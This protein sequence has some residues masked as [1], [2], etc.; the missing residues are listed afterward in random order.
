MQTFLYCPQCSEENP[1]GAK[2]C[3]VCAAPIQVPGQTVAVP[4]GERQVRVGSSP[5][6]TVTLNDDR[7]SGRHCLLTFKPE[8]LYIQDL[9]STNG[10]FV[11]QERLTGPRRLIP[12]DSIHLGSYEVSLKRLV[13]SGFGAEAWVR[14]NHWALDRHLSLTAQGIRV[15]VGKKDR[16]TILLEPTSLSVFPGELCGVMGLAGAGK[17][18]LLKALSGYSR[19]DEGRVLLNDVDLYRNFPAVKRR[20]GYVPQENIFHKDLTVGQALYCA[21]RMRLSVRLDQ[22]QIQRRIHEVVELLGLFATNDRILDTTI[23]QCSGGQQRRINI[24][25]ELLHDPDLLF[26]DEPLSGLSSEDAAVLMKFLKQWVRE[27]KTVLMTLHQPNRDIYQDLD[28]VVYLHK[29]G[30]LVFAGPAV[31]DSFYFALGPEMDEGIF[32]QPERVLEAF[33][34]QAPRQAAEKFRR[35][36]LFTEYCL[37]KVKKRLR[38]KAD[39]PLQDEIGMVGQLRTLFSRTLLSKLRDKG[40]AAILFLQAPIIAFLVGMVFARG[41]SEQIYQDV[42]KLMFILVVAAVWFGCS[43]AAR[44][45]CGEWPIFRRER[46]FNLSIPA[47]LG[48][49][50]G[51]GILICLFQCLLLAVIV[52]PW[53]GLRVSVVWVVFVLWIAASAGS[54]I[55]LFVSAFS[56][57][58]RKSNEIALALVPILLIPMVVLGG[59]LQPIEEMSA[60]TEFLS[61]VTPTR[62]AFESLLISEGLLYDEVLT[63]SGLSGIISK[64]KSELILQP[65][66]GEAP[67]GTPGLIALGP[68]FHMTTA[69]LAAGALLTAADKWVRKG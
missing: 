34:R 24:A 13:T 52:V 5:E 58:F 10:T 22:E 4:V 59:L 8:G 7:V 41:E 25:V 62:W 16:A 54:A 29:G 9:D 21:A 26:L 11:N 37:E 23:G 6:N 19:P 27:G 65:I 67:Y 64:T 39:R 20:L 53:C 28:Q 32:Y 50:F 68:L 61:R 66:I 2:F 46:M 3:E 36:R 30:N 40:N 33:G 44:D 55:G 12:G 63:W 35:T 1:T 43:N 51:V 47:Y 31:P 69:L 42:P 14:F 15:W 56:S 38:G 60:L 45:I 49:K 48:A 18:T 17:T 57:P